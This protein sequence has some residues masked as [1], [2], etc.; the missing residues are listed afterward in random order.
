MS[1]PDASATPAEIRAD[2]VSEFRF[3][4]DAVSEADVGASG[5]SL[6]SRQ[7]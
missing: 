7:A 6:R 1:T 4:L 5:Q 3:I 2:W